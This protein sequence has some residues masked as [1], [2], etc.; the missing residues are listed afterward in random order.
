ML[1]RTLCYRAFA[2]QPA[3][4]AAGA[5]LFDFAEASFEAT[6]SL[7]F[8]MIILFV[9][10]VVPFIIPAT[11]DKGHKSFAEVLSAQ[12]RLAAG[13]FVLAPTMMTVVCVVGVWRGRSLHEPTYVLRYAI[14]RCAVECD[15]AFDVSRS[16]L[17]LQ[18]GRQ[19]AVFGRQS[20][21]RVLDAGAQLVHR[22]IDRTFALSF[23]LL[24]L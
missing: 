12:S 23:W 1:S 2:A 17:H 16:E 14:G 5:T 19:S 20:Q 15:C 21:R 18:S 24:Q 4:D 3:Q 8:V 7:A 13:C 6:F 11:A 9:L 22:V 10:F